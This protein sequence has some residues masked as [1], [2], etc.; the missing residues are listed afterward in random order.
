MVYID[1][2]GGN[3]YLEKMRDVRRHARIFDH[4]RAEAL[5]AGDSAAFIDSVAKEMT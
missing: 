3:I 5:G 1:S 4:L 2:S